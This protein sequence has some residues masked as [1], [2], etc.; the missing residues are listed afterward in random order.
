M[1]AATK[2]R[3][4]AKAAGFSLVELMIA[5]V[6]GLLVLA[7]AT[8][9]FLSNQRAYQASEGLGRIQENS[10]IA[11]EMMGRDIRE[12]GASPCDSTTTT[13]S[14]VVAN[15]A[16]T[17]YADWS[18]P[19]RGYDASGLTGQLAGTDAIQL[20][21]TDDD[22]RSTTAASANSF[23]FTPAK[24]PAYAVND[25]IMVCD[26][27]TMGIF[28]AG[29]TTGTSVEIS[30]TNVNEC[31][32]FPQ[33]KVAKCSGVGLQYRFP[34]F[35]LI[36]RM[37]GVRWLVRAN[38]RNGSSLYRQVDGGTPDEIIQG[39]RDMQIQYLGAAGFVDAD[40]VTNWNAP[41]LRAAKVTL[42]LVETDTRSGTGAAAVPLVRTIVHVT[43]LRNRAL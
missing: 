25:V 37:R 19:L 13:A 24:S 28:S 5:M 23:T 26:M 4:H 7:A 32:Y 36:T 18:N 33:P 39:V 34:R 29:T 14:N 6:L 31:N 42:T 15:Q 17:W 11:F 8:G 1:N 10:Q 21:R 2:L 40:A 9:I 30:A 41:E 27:K 35:S 43:T 16:S 38:G 3:N 12:A 20:V 22:I